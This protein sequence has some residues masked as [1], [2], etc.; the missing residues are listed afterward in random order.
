MAF[1]HLLERYV[2]EIITGISCKN[3]RL[4]Q[5]F[6]VPHAMQNADNV[7]TIRNLHMAVVKAPV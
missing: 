1:M 6:N 2:K 7:N 5:A 4:K 3:K